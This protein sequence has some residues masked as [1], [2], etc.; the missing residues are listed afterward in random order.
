MRA[1]FIGSIGRDQERPWRA[2]NWI[3]AAG[4]CLSFVNLAFMGFGADVYGAGTLEHRLGVR[5]LIVPVFIYRH[6]IQD[7]GRFPRGD[8]RGPGHTTGASRSSAPAS[9]PTWCWRSASPWSPSRTRSRCT[10]HAR[11]GNQ[12]QARLRA[13][14]RRH[15]RAAT[16]SCW[17]LGSAARRCCA[18]W[19]KCRTSAPQAL[20]RDPGAVHGRSRPERC[21]RYH[22]AVRT[23]AVCRRCAYST[24]P[25]RC[26]T[27]SDR[28]SGDSLM[29]TRL[30]VAGPESFIG[31]AMKI[32]LRIQLEQGRDPR[33]RNGHAGAAGLLHPLPRDHRGGADQHRALRRLRAMAAGARSLFAPSRGL[34]GR[35]GGCRGA[36]RTAAGQGG[37]PVSEAQTLAVEVTAIEQITPLIKHFKLA[38]V[39]GGA[40]ARILRR[41]AHHRGDARRHARAPQSLLAA[42]LPAAARHLRDRRAPHGGVARRIALHARQVRVGSRLEIAH[43]VNLFALDKI[44]RKHVLIAGGIGITPFHGA[45]RGS[46]RRPRCR[47]NCIT[48][49]ARP[50]TRP[51]CARLRER[52]GDGVRMYYD[53]EGQAID[54]DGLLAAQPLGTH[55]YVCGPA[56]MIT[57]VIA[58]APEL[59]LARQPH[60][61]G[62]IQRAARGR[63]LRCVPRPLARSRVHV[64]PDQSLLESIEAA[65]VEVPYLCR[66]GVCGFCQT[67][68]ARTRRRAACTTIIICRTRTR[69]R[70]KASCRA[71]PGRAA[72]TWCWIYSAWSRRGT[73]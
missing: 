52:E 30:Y 46:A 63:R 55:V 38:P 27:N 1:G 47:T 65:G 61:L 64:P 5:R 45:A 71:C 42:E 62:A 60:S 10:D 8:G 69:P 48:R 17:D 53:S 51:S 68:G 54:F 31:L 15:S 39:V 14:A 28:C 44:A 19:A 58:T 2:P 32:A 50:S 37:V 41:L 22:R 72:R 16:T 36:G 57:R 23:S 25:R 56:G 73:S 24:P 3:L 20:A 34:H 6:Y 40:H 7:K 21:G 4:A 13:F 59:R 43:P 29:G 33:R 11:H 18:C 67:R 49:Y 26:S 35:H 70:A 66:G 12:E 9:G